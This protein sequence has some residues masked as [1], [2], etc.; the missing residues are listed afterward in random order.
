GAAC[1]AGC[2]SRVG[3]QRLRDLSHAGLRR[4]PGGLAFG[5][6]RRAA[7]AE[8]RV[9]DD[10]PDRARRDVDVDPVALLDEADRAAFGRFR[11]DMADRKARRAAGETAI[12][13]ERARLA[14]PA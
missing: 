6:H 11:R 9:V 1:G 4:L 14:E 12:G 2:E 3:P 7:P 13:D 10:E 5:L 8:R